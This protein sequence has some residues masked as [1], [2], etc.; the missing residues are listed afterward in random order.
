MC[1]KIERQKFQFKTQL[2]GERGDSQSYNNIGVIAATVSDN[3]FKL[4]LATKLF[5]SIV[6][7]WHYHG[8]LSKLLNLLNCYSY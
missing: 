4:S 6:H 2:L 1:S 7:H 3:S 5:L 8:N